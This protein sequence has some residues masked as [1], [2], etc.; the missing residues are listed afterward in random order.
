MPLQPLTGNMK[1]REAWPKIQANDEYLEQRIDDHE[2]DTSNPHN[3]T[4]VQVGAETPAGA[5]AKAN[6]VQANLTAHIGTGGSS[7]AAATTGVAGFQSAADKA[8]L[9]NIASGAQVNQFAFGKI[10]V[11][12]QSDIDADAVVDALKLAGGTGITITTNP[13]T[14]EV[15]ITATGA[16]TPGAHASS[17]IT[18]GT[19]VIPNAV[20][21]G[22]AGLMSGA[23]KTALDQTV[24]GLAAHVADKANPHGTTA[25]QV[26]A[27]KDDNYVRQP[28]FA[29]TA[30]TSTAYTVTL[31]PAPSSFPEGSGITIVPHLTCGANPTLKIGSLAAVSL[32][33]QKGVAYAAGK[34]LAGKPYMFRKVGSDFLADSGSSGGNAQPADVLAPKTFTNDEGEQIGTGVAGRKYANGSGTSSSTLLNATAVSGSSGVK[35]FCTV[36][37]LP[38]QPSVVSIKSVA[39]SIKGTVYKMDLYNVASGNH[40]SILLLND[41]ASTYYMADGTNFYVNATGFRLPYSGIGNEAITWEAWE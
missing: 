11:T 4:A 29:L 30:G 22:N 34:L 27:L 23:D 7:H 35:Y 31:D 10:V 17:H 33:D 9:D 13:V 24:S 2:E 21:S 26:G 6:A 1:L 32:K 5:Q 39:N 19:D 37:G 40:P 41:S 18:G 36:T 14:D 25:A 15:V 8:K 3:V 20:P 12:G 38:F 28:A 16:A